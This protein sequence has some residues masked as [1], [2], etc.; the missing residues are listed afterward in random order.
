MKA[1][2]RTQCWGT[3]LVCSQVSTR[4]A[5]RGHTIQNLERTL[6]EGREC[7]RSTGLFQHMCCCSRTLTHYMQNETLAN[8]VDIIKPT[9]RYV[10]R[11]HMYNMWHCMSTSSVSL[12]LITLFSEML[13]LAKYIF[14]KKKILRKIKNLMEWVICQNGILKFN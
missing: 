2:N 9:R 10:W 1:F 14:Q 5:L 12:T 6:G 11:T 4:R 13:K 3:R 7:R 8:L